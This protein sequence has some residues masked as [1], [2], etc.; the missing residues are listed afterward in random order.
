MSSPAMMLRL[1]LPRPL[2]TQASVRA[3]TCTST[4]D[5]TH[6]QSERS[7]FK[8]NVQIYMQ[9][10][11]PRAIVNKRRG[12]LVLAHRCRCRHRCWSRHRCWHWCW[13]RGC[14]SLHPL[15]PSTEVLYPPCAGAVP[16]ARARILKRRHPIIPTDSGI[17]TTNVLRC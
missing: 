9:R 15:Q 17:V 1:L 10:S 2:F 3:C 14:C 16:S 4:I 6:L 12:S 11:D 8:R 7:R 5:I 13:C